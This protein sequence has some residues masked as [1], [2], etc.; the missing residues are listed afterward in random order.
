MGPKSHDDGLIRE[1]Q[2]ELVTETEKTEAEW[3]YAAQDKECLELPGPG[4]YALGRRLVP[5]SS[6]LYPH[7]CASPVLCLLTYVLSF[8]HLLKARSSFAGFRKG[9]TVGVQLLYSVPGNDVTAPAG[10]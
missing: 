9:E 6:P 5:L 10:M 7:P 8:Y 3:S 4:P 2:T 1:R